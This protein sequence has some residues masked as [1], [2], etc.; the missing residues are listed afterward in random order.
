[1]RWDTGLAAFQTE[2]ILESYPD[3]SDGTHPL[4]RRA[5]G[6]WGRRA[7][8]RWLVENTDPTDMIVGEVPIIGNRFSEF[9]Q[10]QPDQVEPT[11]ASE[12]TTFIY[13][14]PTKSLRADLEAI[15]RSTFANPKHPDEARDAPPPTMELAW[16]LTCA[17]A[18]EL[19]LVSKVDT[20]SPYEEAIYVRFFEHLLQHRNAVRIAV[21]TIY[22]DAGSAHD[23]NANIMELSASPNEV[24][25]AVAEV[26]AAFTVQEVVRDVENW[27]QV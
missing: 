22:S 17:K 5:A 25:R 10:V 9:I 19:G 6:L 4:V 27:Y 1:M 7:L 3:V 15:R 16:R 21:D 20:H 8:A 23:L 18:V 12:E 11:L 2:D 14:V 13:P 24:Q 26:E